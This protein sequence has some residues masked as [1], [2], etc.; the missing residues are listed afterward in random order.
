MTLTSPT[1]QQKDGDHS[2]LKDVIQAATVAGM[3]VVYINY[4]KKI[5]AI[6]AYT[7]FCTNPMSRSKIRNKVI[8]KSYQINGAA[9]VFI[10]I[11]LGR[12]EEVEETFPIKK[13]RVTAHVYLHQLKTKVK[14]QDHPLC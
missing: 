13:F 1:N 2:R 10:S 11:P 3:V 8:F 4:N 12:A 14:V 7:H 5:F 6:Y 9:P